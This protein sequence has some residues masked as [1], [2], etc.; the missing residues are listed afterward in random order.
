MFV[1]ILQVVVTVVIAVLVVWH[2]RE[3]R[4]HWEPGTW[5][6]EMGL[7]LTPS[8]EAIVRS[9]ID[10]TR[11][12][13][14]LGA[15]TGLFA[16]VVYRTIT[17][18]PLPRPFDFALID[19]LAG[20]LVGVVVAEISFRRPNGD[21]RQASLRTRRLRDYLPVHL[22]IWLWVLAAIDLVAFA[23][24][25]LMPEPDGRAKDAVFL[26]AGILVPMV[27]AIAVGIDLLQRW[28]VGQAQPAVVSDVERADDAIRSASVHALA[29]AGLSMLLVIL[30]VEL[31]A[32]ATI[33]E[34]EV[35]RWT[36]PVLGVG[37]LIAA[38][39][40]WIRVGRPG[41]WRVYPARAAA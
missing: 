14:T 28:I 11:T 23:V 25:Q 8:N 21:V 4:R 19:A 33:S 31:V 22:T 38:L 36:L 18:G 3:S 24:Y 17:G 13:R 26:P 27:I 41:G 30:G 7:E 5:A 12:L 16:P 2:V 6:G 32:I 15:V 20:Y 1:L 40:A 39:R 10:R 37:C 29:G 9:Y 34:L 35:V